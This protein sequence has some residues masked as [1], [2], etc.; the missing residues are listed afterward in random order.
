MQGKDFDDGIRD[1]LNS[2]TPEFNPADWARMED[3]LQNMPVTDPTSG[4]AAG[5][6]AAGSAVSGIKLWAAAGLLTIAGATTTYL[7]TTKSD[8]TQTEIA[9]EAKNTLVRAEEQ[10]IAEQTSTLTIIGDDNQAYDATAGKKATQVSSAN[11]ASERKIVAEEVI[12]PQRSE[13]NN[14]N[15]AA[16]ANNTSV[17]AENRPTNIQGVSGNSA[18]NA[19]LAGNSLAQNNVSG[20]SVS[21]GSNSESG[22]S[23]I[24]APALVNPCAGDQKP[25]MPFVIAGLDTVN[26]FE[27]T[28]APC[29]PFCLR[30]PAKV[31]SGNVKIT[32]NTSSIQG[33]E[34]ET[35]P[36]SA[37]LGSFCWTP[38][39]G[40]ARTEP[41]ALRVN[42]KGD[43]CT[44]VQ[45]YTIL[46]NVKP[47]KAIRITGD[48][49]LT[50]GQQ[51]RIRVANNFTEANYSW[52]PADGLIGSSQTREILVAPD[53]TTN[54]KVT[55]TTANGCPLTA[56]YRVKVADITETSDIFV[57]N[58]ITPNGDGLNDVFEIKGIALGDMEVA[59]YN[60]WRKEVYHNNRYDNS[61]NGSGLP[62]G[63]Y[64][65]T[66]K[67][68]STG[69]IFSGRIEIS[70]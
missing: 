27:F 19:S 32:A 49:V 62:A 60:R 26:K 22:S 48:T 70:R 17:P 52:A 66:L 8:S 1:L 56:T 12:A 24:Q 2:H 4:G 57:P 18:H 55:V 46:L 65:Y 59:V 43:N 47:Q 10:S 30:L 67:Q 53:K 13:E 61:W 40:Q 45:S 51:G 5:S 11:Q 36:G 54:Y 42:L 28:L 50:R 39:A 69:K 9:A 14:Y 23:K 37:N 35:A 7:Y 20:G 63:I 6:G 64:N 68:R 31:G 44:E 15:Q 21:G 34:F 3:M 41:Y 25:T 16:G 38:K 58:V 29:E 33:A